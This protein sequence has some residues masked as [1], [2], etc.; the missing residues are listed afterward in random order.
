VGEKA[1]GL[2]KA[3]F[4]RVWECQGGE[5]E[6]GEWVGKYLHRSRGRGWDAA[7]G[8]QSGPQFTGNLRVP[9]TGKQGV[10]T[11]DKQTWTQRVYLSVIFSRQVSEGIFY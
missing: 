4:P 7:D 2:V 8:P 1:L 9:V 10:G 5:A 6:V 11:D 3:Q